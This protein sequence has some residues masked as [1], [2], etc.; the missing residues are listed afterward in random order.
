MG[1]GCVP[2]KPMVGCGCKPRCIGGAKAG[3]VPPRVCC[4]AKL[5]C[6][7]AGWVLLRA[8]CGVKLGCM[9]KAC[10]GLVLSRAFCSP[11]QYGECA[12]C[13]TVPPMGCCVPF[14]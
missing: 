2:P 6:M 4:V 10:A 3:W 13:D 14:Q 5:G 7:G 8:C 9:G 12:G 11:N 1:A